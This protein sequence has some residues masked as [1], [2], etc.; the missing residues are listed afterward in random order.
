AGRRFVSWEAINAWLESWTVT[1][2]DQR[3]H[4]TTHERP[5]ARFARETLTP[6]GAR[7]RIAMS[8]N[9]SAECR[10]MR[11]SPSARHAIRSPCSM[12][13]EHDL[14]SKAGGHEAHTPSG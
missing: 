10:R 6:L 7:A 11:W 1:V 13:E 5:I 2:A 3:V 12:S 4:G 14:I 9:A 8:E